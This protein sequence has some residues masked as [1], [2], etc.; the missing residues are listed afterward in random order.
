MAAVSRVQSLH[1]ALDPR[2]WQWAVCRVAVLGTADLRGKQRTLQW[3]CRVLTT[4]LPGDSLMFYFLTTKQEIRQVWRVKSE[5]DRV[6]TGIGY[7][8]HYS[9]Q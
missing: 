9:F 6:N 2:W 8:L 5:Q 1:T 4:G 3:K 7:I